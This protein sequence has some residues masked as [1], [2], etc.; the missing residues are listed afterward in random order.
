[1][2]YFIAYRHTGADPAYLNELLPA[3]RDAFAESG[4]ETYCTFFDEAEFQDKKMSPAVIMQ[5]AFGKI[6]EMGGLFV[7][8]DG[9]DKSDGQLMEV[10]Y[11][12]AKGIP[13]VV[14]K[15]GTVNNTYIDQ[16]AAES[17]VYDD[18]ESLRYGIINVCKED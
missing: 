18:P 15:R 9:T 12:L 7:L 11:C 3:V 4:V 6:D 1:M 16:L 13:F 17:F 8:V 10:G 5:H 14:A 2:G